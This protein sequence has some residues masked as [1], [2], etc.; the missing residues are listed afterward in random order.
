VR[1]FAFLTALVLFLYGCQTGGKSDSFEKPAQKTSLQKSPDGLVLTVADETITSDEIIT[2]ALELFRPI[3]QSGD[4]ERFKLQ[5]EPQLKEIITARISNI[6]LFQQAKKNTREDIDQVLERPAEAE[7][8]KFIMVFAGDYAKAEEALKQ[9]G[10]DWAGFKQEQKKMIL[11]EYYLASLMPKAGPI[12]YSELLA[13]YNQMKEE[14]FVILAAIKFQL[15][16]IEPSKL[17]ITDPNQNPLEQARKLADKLHKQLK[18]GKDFLELS[19]EYPDVSFA[20]H[21]QPVQPD[22]LKYSVLADE[23]E[24]LEPGDISEPFETARQE[25]IFIMKLEEKHS[26]GYE[27]LEKVQRQVKAQIAFDRRKQA[28]DKI[29]A[30]LRRQAEHELSNEFTEFCLQKIYLISKE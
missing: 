5:A 30:K 16:D 2:T 12:T 28:Q 1:K 26:K 4:F 21:S 9:K 3:A 14:S 22:S 10:M 29:L 13:R 20:A 8:R 27:P 18:A 15:L 11:I 19:N 7:I 23:A 25:H 6:L 24:K 17:R